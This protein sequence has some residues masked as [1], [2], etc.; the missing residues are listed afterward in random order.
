MPWYYNSNGLERGPVSDAEL[1]ALFRA[2]NFNQETLVRRDDANQWMP[3]AT[4]LATMPPP[5]I[6][7]P[8]GMTCAECGRFFPADELISLNRSWVCAQCKPIFLQKLAEG[9]P[10]S[11]AA[12]IWRQGKRLVTRSET[13]FPD[14]CIKCNGPANGYRL[15]RVLYWQHPAYYLLLL[16]N[17]LVLLVVILIVRKKAVLHIGLCQT[18]RDQ[19]KLAI[20]AC[21]TGMLGGV[22]MIIAGGVYANGWVALTGVVL[23]LTGAVWGIVMGRTIAA[24]KIENDIV[25]ISGAGRT[26]LAEFPE[27]PI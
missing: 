15:K 4:V 25:T 8:G 9:V 21:V 26:F 3:L 22:A 14:R 10:M 20:I 13:P 7:N 6:S 27:R 11:G 18:H 16:C 23:F 24:V 12:G 5:L 17:L 2:G 1:Q 19:R